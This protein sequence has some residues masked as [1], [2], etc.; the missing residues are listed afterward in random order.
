MPTGLDQN[1]THAA[2]EHHLLVKFARHASTA[3]QQ[4]AL[5]SVHGAVVD[6]LHEDAQGSVFKVQLPLGQ[7]AD[8]AAQA[9]SAHAGVDYAERDYVLHADF[10]SNDPGYTTGKMWGLEGDATTL[11]NAFGSGAGEAWAAGFVGSTKVAI[12]VID[13]GVDYT[14]PDLYQNIWLNNAEIPVALRSVLVDTDQDGTITF[15]DLDSAANAAYVTDRNGT[16][17]I[18]AGDILKDARWAD[19]IDTDGNGYKDDL[20]GWDFVNNDNDPYDDN[21]HG[22]H[23]SGTIGAT[24]GNGVGAIGVSPNVL[25]VPLKF[26]DST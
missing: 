5:N 16:G 24:G 11:K 20:I 13:S 4:D 21:G 26:L 8:A 22:T 18:D 17:Y 23:V 15:R 10:V 2:D 6:Q 14:H 7:D 3:D 25:I 1:M 12:G 19:G 9:L